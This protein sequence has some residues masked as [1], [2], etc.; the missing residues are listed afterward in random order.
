VTSRRTLELAGLSLEGRS[1]W[2]VTA[3]YV[4]AD[5]RLAGGGLR[6]EVMNGADATTVVHPTTGMLARFM[7]IEDGAG[8]LKFARSYGV[9]G[10]CEHGL[11]ASH[12][13]FPVPMRRIDF[14]RDACLP[15]GYPDHIREPVARWLHFVRQAR[16]L[17]DIAVAVL[18]ARRTWPGK[19]HHEH[20]RAWATV[21]EDEPTARRAQLA[22]EIA[23]D[24]TAS[25][26]HLL[27]YVDQWLMLGN[28]RPSLR[29][30]G[31]GHAPALELGS[32]DFGRTFGLLAIELVVAVTRSEALNVCDGCQTLYLRT[33]R[34]A[35]QQRRNYCAPCRARGVPARDRQRAE[36]RREAN[37]LAL[38]R[39]QLSSR[40]AKRAVR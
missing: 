22:E 28:V 15:V 2:P 21:L 10:I 13:P 11:P 27:R 36:R 37:A 38:P 31:A 16:A 33:G 29:W 7:T 4:P 5:L 24:R 30:L 25:T 39:A 32:Y 26:L 6:Y 9:L 18:W 40:G 34:K 17:L 20:V 1:P 12:N 23:R 35:Q 3:A 14:G 19:D 8:V